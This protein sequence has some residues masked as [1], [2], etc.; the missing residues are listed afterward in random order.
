MDEIAPRAEPALEVR[1]RGSGMAL[2]HLCRRLDRLHD[3]LAVALEIREAQQ[4]LAA[5]PL[6]Q[7]L[8]G[9]AQLEIALGDLETVATFE[10]DLQPVA[11]SL[12]QRVS[13]K[14]D[15]YALARI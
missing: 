6:A 13:E 11:G 14:Q 12:R 4:W 15:A 8:A 2:E 7:I 9:P 1:A 10:D 5:L 3:K